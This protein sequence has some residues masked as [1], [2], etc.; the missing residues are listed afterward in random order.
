MA[1][2]SENAITVLERRYLLKD[3]DGNVTETPE[4]MFRR[5]ADY[6][7]RDETPEMRDNFYS[8]MASL[9]FLPNSPTLSG[10]G[11]GLGQLSAC[12]VLPVEDDLGSIFS[13][14]RAAAMIHKSGGGTG[15]SFGRLRAKGS[16]VRS[17][18]GVAGGPVNF[19]KVF[20]AASASIAQGSVRH[21][22]NMGILPWSHPDVLDFIHMKD[23]G[24]TLQNFNISV[25]VTDDEMCRIGESERDTRIFEH[26]TQSA[27]ETGDPGLIFID[28]INDGRSNPVPSFGPIEATN[29]CGEQPLYPY[30]SCNLGSINL[31]E[32]VTPNGGFDTE[33]LESTVS[34]AVRFLDDVISRTQYP[35]SEIA[36]VSHRIRR[37]GLGVMG[38]ADALAALK[39][40]YAS[41]QAVELGSAMMQTISEAADAAS[42]E[43]AKERGTFPAWD[44]SIYYKDRR[45]LRNSTRT[46]IAPTGT[47]SII[48]GC[49][50]GIEPIYGLYFER[51]HNLDRADP[52]KATEMVE[53]N[54]V[55]K[56]WLLKQPSVSEITEALKDGR[57]HPAIPEYFRTA[58]DIGPIWHLKHQAAFQKWTDN[59]VSKTINFPNHATVKDIAGAY[60]EAWR[61][62]CKGI[63][64][65]RDGCRDVQVLSAPAQSDETLKET[66]TLQPATTFDHLLRE[67]FM[68]GDRRKLPH[69]VTA[70]RR[71][72]NVEG[73]EGYIHVGEFEDGTPGELFVKMDRVGSAISGLVDSV[74]I[75]VSLG[76]Q[77]GVP[78]ETF[79]RKYRGSRFEPAGMTRD[80][81]IPTCTS[82]L[83]YIF[84][85]LE[86]RYV[87][88]NH[89]TAATTHT[90]NF[91]PDCD[92]ATM[93][94]EGC[95][96]C[97][98][99][100]WSRC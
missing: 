77:Q 60:L 11:T 27:W 39:I 72:F 9:Q 59:A 10:A 16:P 13:S 94:E 34:L 54:P 23:D 56:R 93:M 67:T 99:C 91:C 20:D 70:I 32:F 100:G 95:E 36:N 42:E 48:A 53:W 89:L 66:I 74:C 86:H 96:K 12:F 58:H 33:G 97:H 30:D 31:A 21:G 50:S 88:K 79:V 85:W 78:I 6:V 29:P 7:G 92:S 37:I 90:G 82:L 76:L 68:A 28:R 49:S 18:A 63:T 51:H 57:W 61:L 45:M 2:L 83:D 98:Q 3:Q 73:H 44:R 41:E 40:P 1:Q 87:D 43:L 84:H 65:Y 19:M 46:T 14:V 64:I 80:P 5:V 17:T 15:F 35:M 81:E 71:K 75:A 24:K 69:E 47:I 62:G 38:W 25:S 8:M 4:Q 26:I 52:S 22:A 55:F